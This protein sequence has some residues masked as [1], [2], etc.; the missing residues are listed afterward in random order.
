MYKVF[1][2]ATEFPLLGPHF[3]LFRRTVDSDPQHVL[4][5]GFRLS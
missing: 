5:L 2:T 4:A 3:I 1:M